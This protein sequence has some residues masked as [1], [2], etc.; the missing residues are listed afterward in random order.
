[1]GIRQASSG[2]SWPCRSSSSPSSA[3][4]EAAAQAAAAAEPAPH[5]VGTLSAVAAVA[6]ESLSAVVVER[7]RVEVAGSRLAEAAGNL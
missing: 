2:R 3:A 5:F 7:Q 6:I 4:L 1:M